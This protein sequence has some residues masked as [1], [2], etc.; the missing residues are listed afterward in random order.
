M[1]FLK[2]LANW[3]C[4]VKNYY[5]KNCSVHCFLIEAEQVLMQNEIKKEKVDDFLKF[6]KEKEEIFLFIH[7]F[8]AF[9][10]E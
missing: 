2:K 10:E 9:S 3:L 4:L 8:Y 5:N 6:A 7:R 1:E